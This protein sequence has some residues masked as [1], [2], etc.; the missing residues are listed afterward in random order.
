MYTQR[1][2]QTNNSWL[3]LE[4]GFEDLMLCFQMIFSPIL[5]K[6]LPVS[7]EV[8]SKRDFLWDLQ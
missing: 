2:N 4:P 5:V 3:L 6:E 7:P 8:K 1:L